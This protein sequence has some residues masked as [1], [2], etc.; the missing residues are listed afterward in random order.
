MLP[1]RCGKF[2]SYA[3]GC[4]GKYNGGDKEQTDMR[5]FISTDCDTFSR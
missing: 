2:G 3:G 4:H 5:E 1:V